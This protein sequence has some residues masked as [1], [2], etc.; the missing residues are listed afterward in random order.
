MVQQLV[1]N[2]SAFATNERL[3]DMPVATYDERPTSGS[4]IASRRR[5]PMGERN[6][7]T[8]A[9]MSEA[10]TWRTR[11]APKQEGSRDTSDAA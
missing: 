4:H 6:Q 8:S 10:S 5:P 11:L 3:F 7:V 9:M 1:S 2:T